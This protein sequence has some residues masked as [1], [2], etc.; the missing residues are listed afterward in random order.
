MLGDFES[1]SPVFNPPQSWEGGGGKMQPEWGFTSFIIK[2]LRD[3]GLV[4]A[5]RGLF[6]QV[7]SSS[8]SAR[9]ALKM[10]GGEGREVGWL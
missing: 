5:S 8:C 4:T 9:A 1:Q 6:F 10:Q 2:Q 3:L 7:K